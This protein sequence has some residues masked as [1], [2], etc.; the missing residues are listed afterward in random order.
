MLFK[1]LSLD[2]P[3]RAQFTPPADYKEYD[4]FMSLMH[5]DT[6]AVTLH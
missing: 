1:D 2:T 5:G 3:S 6:N 4:N